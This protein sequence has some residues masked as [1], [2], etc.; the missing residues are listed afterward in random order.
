VSESGDNP[1]NAFHGFGLSL[2]DSP[3]GRR[4]RAGLPNGSRAPLRTNGSNN[5][6]IGATQA[7]ARAELRRRRASAYR[8]LRAPRKRGRVLRIVLIAITVFAAIGAGTVG[9]VFA[10]YNA[11]KSQLPSAATITNMEPEIDTSVYDSTGGLIHV[12][13]NQDY[14]H[15]HVDLNQISP[16]F[17]EAIVA[18]EDHNFYT[19]GSWD[20][21]RLVE[22]GVADVTHRGASLQGGSTIT[23]QLAK[24]SL[25]GGADPPQ[26]IDYKIKEIVL[27]NEIALNFTKS[28][29]LDMYVNRIFYGNFAL[30]VGSAAEMYFQK[31]ASQLDLAQAALLA[32]LPQ[33]PSAYNP[34]IHNA[35]DAVNPLAKSRQKAVLQA[36]QA[37]GYITQAQGIAAY[38]EN[39]TVHSWTESEPPSNYDLDFVDYLESYLN[40][41]FPQYASPGGYNIY[42]TLDQAK[43][44]LGQGIVSSVVGKERIK[45]NMGDGALVSLDPQNGEVLAMIGSWNYND[46]YF[47]DNNYAAT[48]QLN[49]GSTT[50]LFTYTTAIASTRFTMTTPILD[51]YF[52]FPIP[53]SA[54][55]KPFDDDR[56]TH[57]VCMLKSCLGNSLNIPAV[58]TEYAVGTQY[59]AN[60]ELAMGVPSLEKNCGKNDQSVNWPGQY[61]WAATLGSLTCGITLLDL[62]DGAS[63]L[64]DLGVQH[65][66]MPVTRIVAEQTGQTVWT[67]NPTAAGRQVIPAN[68][69]F[70]M[71]EI[72]SNDNNRTLEFGRD[73]PLTLNPRRVSAKTGTAEFYLDNLTVGWTPNLLTAVWVG[74]EQMSCLQA[75]D[76]KYMSEQLAK[77][78]YYDD[79]Q[80]AGLA[81]PF[82]PNDLAHYGLQPAHP[83][84]PDCGHLDGVISGYSGAAP[85]W[86]AYMSAALKGVPDTWYTPPP[87]LITVST[88][89]GFDDSN[90]YLP[91]TG[92]DAPAGQCKYYAQTPEPNASCTYAGPS[93]AAPPPPPT[94]SPSPSPGPGGNQSPPPSPSPT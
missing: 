63:T 19:E 11:Y 51:D 82:S 17:K 34:L 55:Y 35:H 27:G 52:P 85:I 30:G 72:T 68:V 58:K 74:N 46:P 7:A 29:V 36:M 48:A 43:Q 90:F 65:N 23:E 50:K 16:Y 22:S 75:K 56:R 61:A 33:S 39:V 26:S 2:D 76:V 37:S 24:I 5:P 25:Y 80:A 18:I 78:H 14:R 79:D 44:N 31:P 20:L 86:H 88:G 92:P 38:D 13:H 4:R 6:G 42:T 15:I 40:G 12:F 47:G 53:G 28:Q 41:A 77:G 64:G 8:H 49:M 94:T 66:P 60:T 57:G 67:Y 70:I 71:D 3:E 45:E 62:A 84:I 81:Y 73:G 1:T 91:G 93:P 83:N 10:G 32:G 87:D 89:Q 69:A 59:I 21:A 9:A 54:P